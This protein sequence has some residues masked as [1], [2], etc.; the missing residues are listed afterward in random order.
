MDAET[1]VPPSA[2]PLPWLDQIE[3]GVASSLDAMQAR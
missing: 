1:K 2:Q 3:R